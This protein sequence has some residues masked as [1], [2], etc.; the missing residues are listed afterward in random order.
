MSILHSKC[1]IIIS[2]LEVVKLWAELRSKDPSTKVGAGVYDRSTGAIYLGYNGF[3]ETV[4]DS[5][6]L[7]DKKKGPGLTKYD[8]V[9]HAETN[10][11]S[12]AMRSGCNISTSFLVCTHIPCLNCIKNEVI[13][14][15]IKHVYYE[16]ES[17]DSNSEELMKKIN[18]ISYISGV[19]LERI[20]N[21][22]D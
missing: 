3:P 6:E 4:V 22:D 8:V 16:S 19:V 15:G 11:L 20:L 12:K 17:Y 18:H 5:R 1:D 7:W 2:V 9:V 14:K 13:A 10:A 21:K